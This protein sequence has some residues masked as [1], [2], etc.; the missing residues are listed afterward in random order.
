[1]EERARATEDEAADVEA[2]QSPS[3]E[4]LRAA[5]GEWSIKLTSR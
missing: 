2:A 4:Q 1:M 5:V 3:L